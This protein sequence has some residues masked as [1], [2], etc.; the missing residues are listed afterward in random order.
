M[1]EVPLRNSFS[2]TPRLITEYR[3]TS[4]NSVTKPQKRY[5]VTL[6]MKD[7]QPGEVNVTVKYNQLIVR[8]E[9]R[10]FDGNRS[11][12]SAFYKSLTLP[13]GLQVDRLQTHM[14]DDGQ[15]KIQA[16]YAI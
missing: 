5:E 6:D 9:R 3:R 11:E 2:E 15:L 4:S 10:Y 16:P 1:I 8:A 7:F 14:D 13:A 12:R